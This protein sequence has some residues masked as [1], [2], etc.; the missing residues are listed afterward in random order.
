M[1]LLYTFTALSAGVE[2]WAEEEDL[3]W[4]DGGHP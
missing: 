3:K 4:E 2:S 1:A